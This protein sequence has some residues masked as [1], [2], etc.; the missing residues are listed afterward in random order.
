M[1][2]NEVTPVGFNARTRVHE[3]G[4]DY[5]VSKGQ[6]SSRILPINASCPTTWLEPKPLTRRQMRTPTSH[7]PPENLF[8]VGPYWSQEA[9][10]TLVTSISAETAAK[11]GLRK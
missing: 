3:Y 1:A 2:R 4:G 7:R 11:Y 10:N 9:I 5:A 6:L 8:C